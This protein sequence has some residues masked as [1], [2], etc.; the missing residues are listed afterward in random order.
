MGQNLA[1]GGFES[2]FDK[3][4]GAIS[5]RR[6]VTG[7]DV[8]DATFSAKNPIYKSTNVYST[9]KW[10]TPGKGYINYNEKTATYMGNIRKE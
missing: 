2:R 6:I 3:K 9:W 5:F 4:T 1:P 10:P 7:S 8:E